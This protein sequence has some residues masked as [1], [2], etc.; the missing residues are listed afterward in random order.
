[1]YKWSE[2]SYSSSW[3]LCQPLQMLTDLTARPAGIAEVVFSAHPLEQNPGSAEEAPEPFSALF[4]FSHWNCGWL[5]WTWVSMQWQ[6][7]QDWQDDTCS[8]IGHLWAEN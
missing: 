8:P 7:W 4:P 1:M 5:C 2:G 6:T 3:Y